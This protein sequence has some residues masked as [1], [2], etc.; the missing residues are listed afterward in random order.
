MQAKTIT[1]EALGSGV[2]RD[3]QLAPSATAAEVLKQVGMDPQTSS[4]ELN[5]PKRLVGPDE[6]LFPMVETGQKLFASPRMRV[7]SEQSE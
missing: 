2:A 5:D 3:I 1:V 6:T 7:G 4:L